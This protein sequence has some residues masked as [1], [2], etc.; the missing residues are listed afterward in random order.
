MEVHDN[1]GEPLVRELEGIVR[2]ISRGDRSAHV[3]NRQWS[4][5][6]LKHASSDL[7]KWSDARKRKS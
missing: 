4:F 2:H 7:K 1:I 5:L 3:Q 6:K